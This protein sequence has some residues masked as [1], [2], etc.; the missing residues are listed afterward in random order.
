MAKTT[1]FDLS[2]DQKKLISDISTLCGVKQETVTLVW[3][4]TLLVNY[5]R[6]LEE[7]DKSYS[8]IQIPLLG[9][10]L[11]KHNSDGSTDVFPLIS[12]LLKETIV[13]IK[14]GDDNSIVRYVQTEFLDKITNALDEAASSPVN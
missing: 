5:L 11:I 13:K 4:Y 7:K 8:K 3:Q 12:E 14:K 1:L 10:V 9:S 2:S 6:L